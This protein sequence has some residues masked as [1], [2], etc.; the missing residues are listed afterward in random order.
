MEK[1]DILRPVIMGE[2]K[3]MGDELK[4]TKKNKTDALLKEYLRDQITNVN[5][6]QAEVTDRVTQFS[7]KG[8]CAWIYPPILR[9]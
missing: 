8:H 7:I 1:M 4:K 6:W 2:K 3:K 5:R 9:S